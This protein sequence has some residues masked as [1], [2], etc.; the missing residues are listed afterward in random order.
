M[1]GWSVADSTGSGDRAISIFTLRSPVV[2]GTVVRAVW[3]FWSKPFHAH[4]GRVWRSEL[5]HLL[6]W[7]LSVE[8]A[9]RHYSERVLF[10]DTEGVRLLV[11]DLGLPFT[12]VV[13]ALDALEDADP[14]WWVLGKLWTYRAQT[15][16][17]VHLDN[18]VFLWKRLPRRLEHAPVCAQNPETFPG[19]DKSWY[20]PLAYDRA[21]RE[22]G[23]WAPDEWRRATA[24]NF[25]RAVCCG[26]LG[27]TA[28][29]FL[30]Y[31]ADL[32]IRMIQHPRNRAAWASLENRVGDNILFEQYLLAACLDHH[33]R[34]RGSPFR[35]VRAEYLFES[36]DDAF[37]EL[38][39][40]AAGYTHLIGEAKKDPEIA[41]RLEARVQRDYP[42]LHERCLEMCCQAERGGRSSIDA[43]RVNKSAGIAGV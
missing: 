28:V 19:D 24:R 14:E 29:D 35:G 9:G 43:R 31:Y 21:L 12:T 1:P 23:G 41:T 39:A 18:D 6:A 3:S 34:R 17:F 5:H 32:A 37:H 20:R 8:L 25:A 13:T 2:G 42:E 16:P 27:G 30:T 22:A 11:D 7:V 33:G 26:I 15:E 4:H 36:S 10:T 40:V 38:T